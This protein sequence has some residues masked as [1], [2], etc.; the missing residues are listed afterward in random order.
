MLFQMLIVAP[1]A[2]AV[3]DVATGEGRLSPKRFAL[4]PVRNPIMLGS[5]VG[6]AIAASGWRPPAEVLEPFRLLGAAAV[7]AAL[8][9]FG[10]SL[11]GSR[12]FGHGP[13]TPARYTAVTLKVLV[14]PALAY[15]IA[16]HGFGL[17][18]APLLAAVVTSALPLGQNVFVFARRYGQAESLAR[19]SVMLSTAASAVV[20]IVVAAVLR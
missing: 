5:A 10:M 16:H 9:A 18:G 12:P 14:Q 2:L 1:V 13:D 6:I 4:L 3:L 15:L 17:D 19:D 7:P 20:M 8:L 11:P